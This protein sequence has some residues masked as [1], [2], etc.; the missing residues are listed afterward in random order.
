MQSLVKRI[1]YIFILFPFLLKAQ[2]EAPL[3]LDQAI[4]KGMDY[5]KQL[6]ISQAKRESFKAKIQQTKNLLIPSLSLNANY[7]RISNNITPTAVQFPGLGYFVLNP[8]ILNQYLNRA[9]LQYPIFAGFR[10]KNGLASFNYLEKAAEL[11]IEKDKLDVRYNIINAYL[12]AVRAQNSLLAID[13]T[14]RQLEIRDANV[15]NLM[16]NGMAIQNDLRRSQYAVSNAKVAREDLQKAYDISLF[17]LNLMLGIAPETKTVL[18]G[19]IENP[20]AL[21]DFNSYMNDAIKQ[22]YDLQAQ[23]YRTQAQESTVKQTRAGYYPVVSLGANYYYNNPNARIFPQADKF[24]DTWDAGAG[25]SWN[26]SGI[27][28]TKAQT[29]D[30]KAVLNQNQ[31]MYEQLGD[32]IKSEVF[33]AYE[34]CKTSIEKIKVQEIFAQQNKENLRVVNDRYKNNLALTSEVVEAVASSLQSDVNL[35]NARIDW[36][37][38]YYKL[39]KATGK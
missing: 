18:Q 11:D 13:S 2:Q 22:R 6:K 28:T 31:L 26:L 32:N 27:F 33:A 14:I 30:A 24:K 23:Q 12:N 10:T 4:Q 1:S 9:T 5:S 21:Q 38:A 16:Q 3:T 19:S 34:E 20:L 15:N 29:D 37:I 25:I 36:Q 8:Q 39:M 17:N 35:L 7:T